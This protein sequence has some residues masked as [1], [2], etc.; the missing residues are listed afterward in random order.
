MADRNYK[1]R[2]IIRE[3][4]TRRTKEFKIEFRANPK[5][6]GRDLASV[7]R[8]VAPAYARSVDINPKKA[9]M[10]LVDVKERK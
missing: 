1:A 9:K 6:L 4:K 3:H 7:L 10:I 2:L 5:K 8:I